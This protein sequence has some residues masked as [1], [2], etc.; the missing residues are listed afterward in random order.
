[1]EE[2]DIIIGSKGK[3]EILNLVNQFRENRERILREKVFNG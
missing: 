1:V 3:G 2:A